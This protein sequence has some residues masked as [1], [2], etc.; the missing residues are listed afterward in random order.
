M[1]TSTLRLVR[2]GKL[3]YIADEQ[4]YYVLRELNVPM[5]KVDR[6][7]IP[8]LTQI[9]TR[10]GVKL[11]SKDFSVLEQETFDKIKKRW[12]YGLEL[13]KRRVKIVSPR[14]RIKK[15]RSLAEALSRFY[16]RNLFDTNV[17]VLKRTNKAF[18][19]V[20]RIFN[21]EKNPEWK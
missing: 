14:K 19:T 6:D 16:G 5:L 18:L 15:A 2:N 17:R 11:V 21:G 20:E 4:S 8:I 1:K 3:F 12:P 7:F 10:K 13:S 9:C